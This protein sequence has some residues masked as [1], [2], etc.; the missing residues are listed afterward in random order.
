MSNTEDIWD[1][2][3]KCERIGFGAYGDVY[4]IKNKNNGY[5]YAL[6]EIDK[7]KCNKS[8]EPLLSEVEIMKKINTE[9]S[10]CV[11]EIFDTKKY[12][13]IIIDLCKIIQKIILKEEKIQ[14]Q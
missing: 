11:K 12:F 10:I 4:K 2:Y 5:Y 9:N 6:K 8:K 7:E 14:L 13:Y 1:K 3:I